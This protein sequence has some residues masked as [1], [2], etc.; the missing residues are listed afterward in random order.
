MLT[1]FPFQDGGRPRPIVARLHY[2]SDCVDILNKAKEMKG[3]KLRNITVSIFPD[4]TAKTARARAA[5]NDVRR[6]LRD[7]SGVRFGLFYP[8]RL[9]ITYG[10]VQRDFLSPVEAEKYIGLMAK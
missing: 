8:A 1:E 2:Y 7:I 3:T 6:Q 10:N 4:Y 5:F 9:R